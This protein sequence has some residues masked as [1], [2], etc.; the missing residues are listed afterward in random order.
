[1]YLQ[2][3][4]KITMQTDPHNIWCRFYIKRLF[5]I[6]QNVTSGAGGINLHPKWAVSS[7]Q[8]V[9]MARW[10]KIRE[11]ERQSADG[12]SSRGESPLWPPNRSSPSDQ[13]G[14]SGPGW[15]RWAP[16]RSG[17]WSSIWNN[18]SN[19]NELKSPPSRKARGQTTY[20][21]FTPNTFHKQLE[22]LSSETLSTS[23]YS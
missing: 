4:T 15:V 23:V 21:E 7:P 11:R 8:S 13:S 2:N 9:G 19:S 20:G 10:C 18:D 3:T 5:L 1:M 12:V 14:S 22:D 16:S 6:K 17:I